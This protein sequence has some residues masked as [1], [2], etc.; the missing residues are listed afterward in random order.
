MLTD[1]EAQK[2]T[3]WLMDRARALRSAGAAGLHRRERG[4]VLECIERA[5]LA[6]GCKLI[7]GYERA[8]L[9]DPGASCVIKLEA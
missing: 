7:D 5:E 6:L 4:G 9:A 1:D 8:S 2:L 3:G